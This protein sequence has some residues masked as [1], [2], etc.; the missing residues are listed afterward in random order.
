MPINHK[1]QY[2]RKPTTKTTCRCIYILT[3]NCCDC[4]PLIFAYGI[5]LETEREKWWAREAKA[6]K[7]HIVAC[8]HN[9]TYCTIHVIKVRDLKAFLA[10]PFFF[11]LF[12]SRF[13]H[14]NTHTPAH[15]CDGYIYSC[16][17][18]NAH[19]NKKKTPA[20]KKKKKSRQK[21]EENISTLMKEKASMEVYLIWILHLLCTL[22]KN[23]TR[24]PT[25]S[26]SSSSTPRLV[27]DI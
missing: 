6:K 26:S 7:E 3:T 18:S 23:H 11:L 21:K 17:K 10:N 25:S 16:T 9:T 22:N 19:C 27:V 13:A 5:N 20:S 2:R 15:V 4:E 1:N 12:L 8:I 24:R 14:T